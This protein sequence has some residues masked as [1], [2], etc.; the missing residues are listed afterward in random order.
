VTAIAVAGLRYALATHGSGEPLV[1]IHGFT[2]S[3][4]TWGGHVP[5]F[6]RE[7]ET[8]AVDLPGHGLTPPPREPA[9]GSVE[10]IADDLAHILDQL[11]RAPA[12]VVAYS[13]GARVALRL[14]VAHPGTIRRL[15]LESPS[16][17]IAD[18]IERKARQVSDDAL[19]DR[20]ERNG[21]AA[22]VTEWERSP[23]I[24]SMSA[25]PA[26]QAAVLRN[27]RLANTAEGLASSLRGAGQGRMEPLQDRLGTVTAPTLVLAGAL[28]PTG[29]TRAEEVA[30]GI[31]GA[32]LVVLP[33][34]GHAPHLERPTEFRSL[35]LDFLKED[36]AA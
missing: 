13:L 18:P 5:A 1:L 23:V 31:P 27:I 6:A 22:F 36:R 9:R 7:F 8:I 32:R 15:V 3:A 35:A 29:T 17:G 21:V 26:Q 10:R 14:A 11:G 16:A 28:D 34:A 25:L 20:I 12:H 4:A 19:A 24:A 2:G 33:D 30:A